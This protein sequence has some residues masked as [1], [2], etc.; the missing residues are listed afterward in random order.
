MSAR[1]FKLRV[2]LGWMAMV[3][4]LASLPLG[5]VWKQYAYVNLSRGL[6]TA[7]KDRGRLQNHVMLLE[8]EVRGLMRP[9]RLE[10]LARDHFGLVDHG[11]P[12]DVQPADQILANKDGSGTNGSDS[13]KTASW[14]GKARW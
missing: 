2:I 4:I 8:T 14:R 11:P 6:Q 12:I 7:E 13:V 1:G 3:M 9:S 5:M 10:A